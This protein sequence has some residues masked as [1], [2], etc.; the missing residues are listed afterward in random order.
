[1]S[2]GTNIAAECSDSES[3][4]GFSQMHPSSV[5]TLDDGSNLVTPQHIRGWLMASL[6]DS[7]ASHSVMPE[8]SSG[9]PTNETC[10]QPRLTPFALFDHTSASWKTSQLSLLTLISEPFSGTWPKAGIVCAGAAYRLRKWERRISEIEYGLLPTPRN[11][12]GPSTDA[13][14]LSLD[15][16][17]KL[18]PTPR[19]RESGDYQYSRGDKTKKVLTL[20]GAVKMFPSPAARDWRSGKGRL[21]NGHS[22]QLAEVIG[23]QLNPM[24]V[25][26]LMGW[27]IGWT[28]LEPLATGKFRQWLQ[29]HGTS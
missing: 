6:A 7:P 28:A 14:H 13:K 17:V 12:T 23:G 2:N 22:P 16:W 25:E 20:T 1:M 4:T 24:W 15:G 29:Q 10:G 3:K 21:E 5:V 11:N 9:P 18:W 19:S 27:P 8:S 26:W